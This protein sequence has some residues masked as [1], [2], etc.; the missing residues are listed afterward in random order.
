M[1]GKQ[2]T[3]DDVSRWLAANQAWQVNTTADPGEAPR[4]RTELCR[5][6][7]FPSFGGALAFMQAAAPFIE[8]TNH[9]PRWENSF[10][11]VTVWLTTWDAGHAVTQLDLDLAE[12][13]DAVGR[14]IGA[15][16]R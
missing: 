15:I 4:S 11:R 9:H 12:H 7:T 14:Q 1:N 10:K 13:L 2:L 3:A 16:S 5:V 6:Y 8:R